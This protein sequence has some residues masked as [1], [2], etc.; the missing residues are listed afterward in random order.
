MKILYVFWKNKFTTK[1]LYH[2]MII[3]IIISKMKN[4]MLNNNIIIDEKLKI[5]SMFNKICKTIQC[6]KCHQHEH[7]TI[8]YTKK[9]MRLLRKNACYKKNVQNY[10][11]KC[12][13]CEKTHNSWKKKCKKKTE[14]NW[15]YQ[16][17]I[18]D[19]V[20]EIFETKTTIHR[21]CD[22]RIMCWILINVWIFIL[23]QRNL[24]FE[25]RLDAFKKSNLLHMICQIFIISFAI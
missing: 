19:Y 20:D 8:Q 17:S 21:R 25:F 22:E 18:L 10:K 16:I 4:A 5:C 15:T 2:I 3:E 9:K 14:K 7:I 12:C 24:R 1:Q 11:I 13:V 6:Y 23:S